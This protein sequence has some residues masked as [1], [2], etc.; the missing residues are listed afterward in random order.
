MVLPAG[1]LCCSILGDSCWSYKG[2]NE[3]GRLR[4]ECA[5][6]VLVVDRRI[7]LGEEKSRYGS[8][9]RGSRWS[10]EGTK[11]NVLEETMIK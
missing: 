8:R 9:R 10:T 2:C 3:V 11:C 1:D 4:E 5:G 7:S 6:I